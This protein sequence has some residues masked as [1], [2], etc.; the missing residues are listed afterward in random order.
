MSSNKSREVLNGNQ[1]ESQEVF[2]HRW[3][4]EEAESGVLNGHW[5]TR[6]Q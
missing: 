5:L 4:E 1:K 3:C 6:T 2:A